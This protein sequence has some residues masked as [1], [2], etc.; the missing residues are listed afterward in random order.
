MAANVERHGCLE[1]CEFVEGYFEH[2]LPAR[3]EP[4]VL[5]FIDVDLHDSLVDCLLSIWPRLL[6]DCRLYSHEA[7]DL[8]FVARFFDSAWWRRHFG[9]AAPGFV[10]AGTGLPVQRIGAGSSLGYTTKGWNQAIQ[11]ADAEDYSNGAGSH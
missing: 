8:G 10:G 11:P 1:V 6:T 3:T 7:Q 5:A 4:L 9:T 2:T